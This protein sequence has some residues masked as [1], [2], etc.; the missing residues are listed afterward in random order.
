[1]ATRKKPGR[2]R[3]HVDACPVGSPGI[4]NEPSVPGNCVEFVYN[5]PQ[6]L[7]CIVSIFKEYDSDEVIIEFHHDRIVFTGKDHSL[8]VDIYIVINAADMNLYYYAPPQ[9]STPRR[10]TES[11]FPHAPSPARA[12]SGKAPSSTGKVPA[13]KMSSSPSSRESDLDEDDDA[14]IA[15][16]DI[17]CRDCSIAPAP[18]TASRCAPAPLPQSVSQS[19]ADISAP[20]YRVVV[21]RDNLEIVTAIIEKTHYKMMMVLHRDDLSSLFITLN[22]CDYDSEDCFE[23]SIVPRSGTLSDIINIPDLTQYPLEFTIDSH[24]LRRKIGELKKVSPD[25][26]IKKIG[27][28]DL[29][30]TFGA[31]ARVIYTGTYRAASKIK[32]RSMIA[33]GSI[34]VATIGI[35]RIRPLMAVNIPGGI[36][37]FANYTDPLA[38]QVGLDQRADNHYA[39][40]AKLL[41]DTAH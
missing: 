36:T 41:I 4:V 35:G 13:I 40:T 3:K 32:L 10:A 6:L 17:H 18:S 20:P 27:T 30:I 38:I 25:M 22:N 14:D 2:P 24:H 9:G 26:I 15:D 7:K 5:Q 19:V 31:V 1:M 16:D 29:E 28:S 33:D 34:F 37:F 39:I 8:C 12:A 23:I 11:A 21:K